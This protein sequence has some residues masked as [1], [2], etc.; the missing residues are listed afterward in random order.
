MAS[1]N[2]ASGT[3]NTGIEA[4]D[5]FDADSASIDELREHIAKRR[6]ALDAGIG[7]LQRRA[8]PDYI[9]QQV[10]D[11]GRTLLSG[12]TGSYVKEAGI[13]ARRSP[14]GTALTLCGL[15]LLA[16][17][18]A[19][20]NMGAVRRENGFAASPG[21]D[22]A[23]G[24]AAEPE[25]ETQPMSQAEIKDALARERH[26]SP[27]YEVHDADNGGLADD[28][29]LKGALL[30]AGIGLAVGGYVAYRSKS[31][32]SDSDNNYGY[33]GEPVLPE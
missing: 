26:Y 25:A 4:A 14:L 32:Q 31:G 15:A 17:G 20:A 5:D 24:G 16:R 8:N 23:S 11:S 9:T 19:D 6:S 21:Q 3:T 10:V 22:P 29:V 18:Y 12:Q 27:S 13:I 28:A 7:E 2:T 1:D 30:A 33:P